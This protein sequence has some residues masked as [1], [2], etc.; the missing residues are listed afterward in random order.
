MKSDR[1]TLAMIVLLAGL[2][3]LLVYQGLR[4]D[5][6]LSTVERQVLERAPT[7]PPLRTLPAAPTSVA[8]SQT[9]Y[10]PIYSHVYSD[11]GRE[12]ALEA[13]LSLRNTDP[14]RS[15]VIKSIRYYDN[16]GSL[17]REYLEAPVLLKPLASTD[18]LVERR[19]MAGGVGANF[20]VDWVAEEV[21]STPIIEAIMVSYGGNKAF[22]FSRAGHPIASPQADG[23]N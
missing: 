15:I 16:E 13:T 18:F 10:V 7:A 19:D 17:L 11:Q 2:M 12:Q 8:I 23:Q 21:V 9:V 1:V 14:D 3:V 4:F 22:A 20:L 5:H 6:H